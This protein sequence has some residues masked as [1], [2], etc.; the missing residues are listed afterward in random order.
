[1]H[2]AIILTRQKIQPKKFYKEIEL[3]N[4]FKQVNSALAYLQINSIAHRDVKPQNIIIFSQ[5]SYKLADFGEAQLEKY[6]EN[7][8]TSQASSLE[9]D[10][11]GTELFMSPTLYFNFKKFEKKASHNTFKSDVFSL[12][13]CML[14]ASS[15]SLNPVDEIREIKILDLSQESL[16]DCN[17]KMKKILN[18]YLKMRFSK[19]FLDLISILLGFD[20]NDRPDFL[21][22]EEIL[23]NY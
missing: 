3:I 18:T 21:E 15:L 4:I 8:C 16:N 17:I 7:T 5:E 12:G 10:I 23:Q 14:Y 1:M 6:Q 19:G 2:A 20:E 9:R 13:L 11:I 22:L